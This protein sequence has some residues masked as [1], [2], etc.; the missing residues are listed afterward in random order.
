MSSPQQEAQ[1]ILRGRWQLI[2][3]VYQQG[4][5]NV[6]G[7]RALDSSIPRSRR[8]SIEAQHHTARRLRARRTRWAQRDS[9]IARERGRRHRPCQRR[10]R[11]CNVRRDRR[12]G[13]RVQRW[14]HDCVAQKNCAI[15]RNSS[16][17][18]CVRVVLMWSSCER[19][20]NDRTENGCTRN[21][22][23]VTVLVLVEWIGRVSDA[24]KPESREGLWLRGFERAFLLS[25]M[26]PC[27]SLRSPWCRRWPVG[28]RAYSPPEP[29]LASDH[30]CNH[31][32]VA[33]RESNDE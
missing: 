14:K 5:G 28:D 31:A 33:R 1:S 32:T 22:R 8:P 4:N 29:K 9:A 18:L 12:L 3:E 10:G 27:L 11:R 21:G 17:S 15:R 26:H 30:V 23:V 20:R 13:A 6:N 19:I 24:P 2:D 25:G 7:T 16:R